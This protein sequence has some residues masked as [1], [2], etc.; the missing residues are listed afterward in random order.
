MALFILSRSE[1]MKKAREIISMADRAYYNLKTNP[2]VWDVIKAADIGASVSSLAELEGLRPEKVMFYVQGQKREEL[3]QL[4][5]SG[6]EKFVVDNE[7][8]LKKIEEIG[9]ELWI[10][11]KMREHTFYTG[12]YFVYGMGW[13]RVKE[14]LRRRKANLMFHRKTQN[15]GEWDLKEEFRIFE[16]VFSHIE[17]INIGGGLPA[18]YANSNP[19]I[20]SIKSRIQDFREYLNDNGILMSMEPGRYIAAPSVRLET[21]VINAYGNTLVVDASIFNA[22][23]D[24]FL[25]NLRLPVMGEGKG[26]RKYL[27]KGYSM[28]SL[29][30]FRYKVLMEEKSIGDKI[31]FLNAGAYN[32]YT[33]FSHLPRIRTEVVDD[34]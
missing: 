30:I 16:D 29:D 18:R 32:F 13:E 34:F 33:E 9:G 12:K 31:I 6:I 20:P 3:K 27:I 26:S 14:I 7:N 17:E 10:R 21:E 28:D 22:S 5:D 11:V 1:A 24:T 15:V 25:L 2:D 4:Y 8:D 23:M 19:D